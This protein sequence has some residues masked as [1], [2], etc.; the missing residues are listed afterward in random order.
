MV[1]MLS[2]VGDLEIS[3]LISTDMIKL[4]DKVV[5]DLSSDQR[6]L[7]KR[8]F[9]R[10]ELSVDQRFGIVQVLAKC[11]QLFGDHS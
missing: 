4:K 2:K 10:V 7:Y 11:T 9:A 1:K 5:N 3:R 6:L 8:C